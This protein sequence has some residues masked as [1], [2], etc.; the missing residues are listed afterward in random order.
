MSESCAH[1]NDT[2]V[3]NPRKV[4]T[5]YTIAFNASRIYNIYIIFAHVLYVNKLNARFMFHK[6]THPKYN[7]V[8]KT[9]SRTKWVG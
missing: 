1:K 9:M 8:L 5:M 6:I 3:V 7:V 2:V 4:C